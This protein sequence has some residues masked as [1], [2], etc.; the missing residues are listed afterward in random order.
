ME[1]KA[2]LNDMGSEATLLKI[3]ANREKIALQKQIDELKGAPSQDGKK[4]SNE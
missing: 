3:E 4:S 1:F 2:M